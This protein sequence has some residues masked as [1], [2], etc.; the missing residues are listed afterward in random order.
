MALGSLFGTLWAYFLASARKL[1][2]EA[3]FELFGPIFLR[4][5]GNSFRK[6]VWS[7]L[8]LFCRL[9]S[10][11][12]PRDLFGALWAYFLASA[13]KFLPGDLFRVSC[14]SYRGRRVAT[15][16]PRRLILYQRLPEIAL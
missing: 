1:L 4:R 9:G 2:Q 5:L 7:P 11:I 13:R 16:Q 6:L 14:G 15:E 8:G 3:C 12:A 10:E